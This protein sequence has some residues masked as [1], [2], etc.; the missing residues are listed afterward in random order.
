MAAQRSSETSGAGGRATNQGRQR[1]CAQ[2]PHKVKF[3]SVGDAQRHI[4]RTSQPGAL[5]T[6]QAKPRRPYHCPACGWVHVSKIRRRSAGRHRRDG[7]RS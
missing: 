4:E 5:G 3:F 2:T 6:A 7:G 1:A